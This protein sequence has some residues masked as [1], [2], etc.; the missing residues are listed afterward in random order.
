[1]A[2]TVAAGDGGGGVGGDGV[3]PV[4]G[5]GVGASAISGGDDYPGER[6]GVECDFCDGVIHSCDSTA[7]FCLMLILDSEY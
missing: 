2:D 1:M 7:V 5:A 3:G 4:S 6:G